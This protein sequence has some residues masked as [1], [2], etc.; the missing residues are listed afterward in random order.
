MCLVFCLFFPCLWIG[1]RSWWARIQEKQRVF[2]WSRREHWRGWDSRV[3][4]ESWGSKLSFPCCLWDMVSNPFTWCCL[5]SHQEFKLLTDC[6]SIMGLYSQCRLPQQQLLPHLPAKHQ[7]KYVCQNTYTYTW[8]VFLCLCLE[9]TSKCL[10][11]N[12]ADRA[13]PS[14]STGIE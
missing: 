3:G 14:N 10:K 1:K 9:M 11:F 5:Q 8:K 12:S 2:T 7:Q 6:F 4:W 13:L